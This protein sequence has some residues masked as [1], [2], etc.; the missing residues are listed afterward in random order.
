MKQL[1]SPKLSRTSV[2][3]SGRAQKMKMNRLLGGLLLTGV[4]LAPLRPAAAQT[5]GYHVTDL[6]LIAGATDSTPL[7]INDSR[8]VAGYSKVSAKRVIK[9]RGWLWNPTTGSLRTLE[10]FPTLFSSIAY[11]I[12]SAGVVVG[13]STSNINSKYNVATYWE[14]P[15][16]YTP[17]N[18]NDMA[19]A[20]D[21]GWTFT[22]A[23]AISSNPVSRTVDGVVVETGEVYVGGEGRFG[24][25]TV[26]EGIVWRISAA[27]QIVGVARLNDPYARYAYGKYHNIYGLNNRGQV[28]GDVVPPDNST[29]ASF[30]YLWDGFSG[31][32][33]QLPRL[34]TTNTYGGDLN[35]NGVVVGASELNVNGVARLRGFLWTPSVPNGTAGTMVAL[36]TLGG[37]SSDTYGINNLNQV[38]GYATTIGD[39]RTGEAQRACLWQNGSTTPTDLN[40]P[41][42]TGATGMTLVLARQINN[43]GD[44]ITSGGRGALLTP[45]P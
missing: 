43:N 44:I 25:S 16:D 20:L 3:M 12:D 32:Y 24:T 7:A 37:S 17:Q 22:A 33:T 35:D 38:V 11:G 27:R 19:G 30:A 9:Y 5:N 39:R 10:P 21:T 36:G 6:G 42:N 45:L 29:D 18:F 13:S 34:G 14:S 41:K 8:W 26:D 40:T 23:T 31:S 2:A 15:T 4:A 28:T 1:F